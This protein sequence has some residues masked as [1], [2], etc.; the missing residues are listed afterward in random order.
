M[1]R[2]LF[3]NDTAQ[4]SPDSKGLLRAGSLPHAGSLA[5]GLHS[6]GLNASPRHFATDRGT[7]GNGAADGGGGEGGS[8][9]VGGGSGL[10]HASMAAASGPFVA[11]EIDPVE[12]EFCRDADGQRI[13]L[14]EGAFGRVRSCS[15][16]R[17]HPP[18]SCLQGMGC[19][20]GDML[21]AWLSSRTAARQACR[22][23][24]HFSD[25]D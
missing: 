20:P 25:C 21:R 10:Q 3:C 6:S 8:S 22:P 19:R 12:I 5:H 7:Y 2:R 9:G 18:L 1:P 17:R 23:T 15:V 11:G 14:G 16:P 4:Q 13:V 24:F